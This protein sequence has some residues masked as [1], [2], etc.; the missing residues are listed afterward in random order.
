MHRSGFVKAREQRRQFFSEVG[1]A[2]RLEAEEGREGAR[3]KRSSILSEGR[4]A[5]SDRGSFYRV[6]WSSD[7]FA[8][9]RLGERRSSE[10]LRSFWLKNRKTPSSFRFRA[11]FLLPFNLPASPLRPSWLLQRLQ[12]QDR[13]IIGQSPSPAFQMRSW[14]SSRSVL[15]SKRTSGPSTWFFALPSTF[16]STLRS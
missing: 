14:N 16:P 13:R 12:F 8:S 6:I 11:H 4:D 3:E 2:E 5:K 7:S 10:D 1:V 15:P 9:L